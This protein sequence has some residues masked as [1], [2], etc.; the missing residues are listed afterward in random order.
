MAPCP[1]LDALNQLTVPQAQAAFDSLSGEG[2]AA[3]QNAAHRQTELFTSS[4]FDQTTFYGGAGTPNSI[5]LTASAARRRVLRFGP[6]RHGRGL[7]R[8]DP[9]NS[10]ICRRAARLRCRRSWHRS[11]PGAPGRPALV[12]SKTSPGQAGVG[13]A[14][15]HDTIYGGTLGVDYQLSPNYL[16]GV[17]IGGSDGVVPGQWSL[18]P[19]ARP[20]AGHIAFYDIATFG[21][22]YGASS[23]SASFFS[24]KTT[25]VIAGFGGLA[26]ETDRGTFD[27]HEF[28]H[29]A[30]VSGRHFGATDLGFGGIV[31]P[32]IALELA[33]LRSNGFAER[34]IAGPTVLGLNVQ[35]QDSASVPSF[36]GLRYQGVAALGN[37]MVLSPSLQVAYVHEFAPERTQIGGLIN[38]PGSTF[39]RRWCPAVE[40]CRAGQGRCGNGDRPAF[41]DLCDVRR[42]ILRRG[43]VL[44]R[45]GRVQVR[46]LSLSSEARS[47]GERLDGRGLRRPGSQPA[48][49]LA[50]FV[51]GRR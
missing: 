43:A 32:F 5:T 47:I 1:I 20:P 19:R 7:P 10:P 11:A 18:P 9:R 35:G 45:Q 50:V 36:V 26:G 14:T 21:A 28:P 48:F 39:P 6:V 51:L 4:I 2:I 25:R 29:P 37:G 17:A 30:R 33:E 22:F 23:N 8:A 16:A 46:L 44:R 40:Q 13:S 15:Q 24:N 3:A 38:L 31:T 41:G 34:N 49:M 42:R 27:S 12:G